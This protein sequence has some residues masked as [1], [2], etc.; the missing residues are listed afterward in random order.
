MI[1]KALWA[2][3]VVAVAAGCNKPSPSTST[4][5]VTDS[6]QT[7]KADTAT[8][9]VKTGYATTFK[10]NPTDHIRVDAWAKL[11]DIDAGAAPQKTF[12]ISDPATIAKITSLITALP[13]SGQIMIKMSMEAPLIRTSF[14]YPNETIYFEY[15]GERLKSPATSFY[16][17][18]HPQEK[19]LYTV[20]TGLLK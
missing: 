9:V 12:D 16:G 5:T 15:F 7:V 8:T 2:A 13:D 19:E 4:E 10:L 3:L 18:S 14:I 17:P 1:Q 20:L 11:S 6:T